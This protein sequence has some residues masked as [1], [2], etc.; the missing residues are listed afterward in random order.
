[1]K[2]AITVAR[3]LHWAIPHRGSVEQIRLGR[4]RDLWEA[5]APHAAYVP[6]DGV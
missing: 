6:A 1:M 3:D 2:E 4:S 5:K